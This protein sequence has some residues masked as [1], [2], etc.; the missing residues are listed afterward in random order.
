MKRRGRTPLIVLVW[1]A[2]S[3]GLFT[4]FVLAVWVTANLL[5][6]W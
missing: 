6:P 3:V 2:G 5:L 4:A 1:L